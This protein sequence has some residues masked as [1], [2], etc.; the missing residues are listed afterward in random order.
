MERNRG[1]YEGGGGLRGGGMRQKAEAR[2]SGPAPSSR[3]EQIL[4]KAGDQ[5]V[6]DLGRSRSSLLAGQS[7]LG[8][9]KTRL[10]IKAQ[11]IWP[12]KM[13]SLCSFLNLRHMSML[14]LTQHFREVYLGLLS[15]H[16]GT[17]KPLS[18][19]SFLPL[20]IPPCSLFLLSLQSLT[21]LAPSL[22]PL[23]P[24]HC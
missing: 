15:P 4:G 8:K 22:F 5:Q 12:C 11:C 23:P 1:R 20:Y 16:R 7:E 18:M 3:R 21:L 19:L 14:L 24:V 13:P 6:P 17:L 10:C 2:K 9:V